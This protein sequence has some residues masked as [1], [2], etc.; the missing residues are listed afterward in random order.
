MDKRKLSLSEIDAI[1]N[2]LSVHRMLSHINIVKYNFSFENNE[3]I[4]I[5][6]ELLEGK[7]LRTL[8]L[9][10]NKLEEHKVLN[11]L[12]QISNALNYLHAN[13]IVHRDMKPEN[14][15][16]CNNNEVKIIDFGLATIDL[17]NLLTDASGTMN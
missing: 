11:I 17:T 15:F 16:I 9:E 12:I 10:G 13:H 8:L 5:L 1:H 6:M 7:D 3:R 4:F 14:I 2:E